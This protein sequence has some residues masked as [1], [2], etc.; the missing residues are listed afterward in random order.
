LKNNTQKGNYFLKMFVFTMNFLVF[1]SQ[2]T[3]AQM[4]PMASPTITGTPA[5]IRLLTR[6]SKNRPKYE[7]GA[8]IVVLKPDASENDKNRVGSKFGTWKKFRH[9]DDFI[10][11]KITNGMSVEDAIK[12]IQTDPAVK[13]AQPNYISYIDEPQLREKFERQLP[14]LMLTPTIR[15]TIISFED[16]T[17]VT[18]TV[19]NGKN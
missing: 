13:F 11:V 2:F 4:T 15:A 16:S 7:P 18:P 9:G 1:G 17:G 12:N 14:K 19:N 3:G 6:F 10:L 8:M 5:L